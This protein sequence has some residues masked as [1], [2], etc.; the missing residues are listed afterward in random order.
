MIIFF[1]A[2]WIGFL[3]ILVKIGVLGKW[4]L[5]MKLS[6]IVVYALAMLL[7]FFPLNWSAP[8]GPVMV[9]VYS[10]PI[11][12]AVSGP[13]TEVPIESWAP[14]KKG[15]VLFRID[16]EPFAATVQQA[17]ARL[18]LIEE[19]YQRKRKLLARQTVAAADVDTL[20]TEVE[21]AK[22]QLKLARVDLDDTVVRA[23]MDGIVPATTLLPGNHVQKG[24]EVLT[25]L[26]VDAPVVAMIVKQNVMRN[27][28]PN[29]PAEVVFRS[30]PGRT[31]RASVEKLFLSSRHAEYV[32]S[33]KTP[34]LPKIKDTS[35]GVVLKVDLKGETITP[36]ASGQA[37]IFTD[38]VGPAAVIRR[39]TLRMTTWLNYF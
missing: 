19:Q 34:E 38:E 11:R 28:R 21:V 18:E 29:Q 30:L 32:S 13:V 5:W 4:H 39:I 24:S 14:L 37:A 26:N 10:I 7:I 22:A 3:W 12:P 16:P 6:P 33:G 2:M 31:F 9:V 1:I 20:E 17:E 35:Y 15:D 8:T 27:V 23:P 25:V 36:G